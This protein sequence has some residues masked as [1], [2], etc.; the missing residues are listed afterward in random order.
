MLDE[1]MEAIVTQEK[2]KELFTPEE[3]EIARRRLEDLDYFKNNPA[4]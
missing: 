4:S 2:Y 1:S 3:I